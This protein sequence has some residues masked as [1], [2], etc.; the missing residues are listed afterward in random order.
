[1]ALNAWKNVENRRGQWYSSIETYEIK[2]QRHV[3]VTITNTW[4]CLSCF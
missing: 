4:R 3:L 1:M 2:K